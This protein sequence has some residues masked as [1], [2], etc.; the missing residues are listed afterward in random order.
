MNNEKHDYR[1]VP[2]WSW[3]GDLNKERL[4]AQMQDMAARGFGGF[5]MHARG[6]LKTEYLSEKWFDMVRFCIEKGKEYGLQPWVYDENGWPSGFADGKLLK[7]EYYIA[8][9]EYEKES[10]FCV[11]ALGNY[12]QKN[13]E[14]VKRLKT[15][16]ASTPW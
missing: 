6:G 9:L 13:G 14:W 7:E 4:D 10:D 5:F 16:A 15:T 12:R 3:N 11:D 1:V 8:S 2:F